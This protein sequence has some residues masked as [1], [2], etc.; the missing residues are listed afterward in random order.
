LKIVIRKIQDINEVEVVINCAD[1]NKEV[2][3]IVSALNSVYAKIQGRRENELFQIDINEI[4][5][6]ES[7]DRKTFLYSEVAVYETE[8]RIY[9]LEEYLK[10]CSF[11][12]ASKS[13]IVN[14]KRVKSLRPEIGLRL[15]LT[16][17]NDEKIIASRQYSSI[18]KQALGVN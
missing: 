5:Y 9:E 13:T 3:K 10:H 17:D 6:I 14:L 2:N 4:L 1:E 11:F 7:V 15:L 12:R 8:K 18:I 16:M